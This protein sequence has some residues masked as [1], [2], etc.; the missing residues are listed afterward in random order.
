MK[1]LGS[2]VNVCKIYCP[3][4][5]YNSVH[6]STMNILSVSLT[7]IASCEEGIIKIC[8]GGDVDC[9]TSSMENY[10]VGD[11]LRVGRVEVCLG[12]RYGTICEDTWDYEDAS[13]VCR[14]LNFSPYGNVR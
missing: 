12:G 13:V 10:L 1:G 6:S 7:S 2:S 14:Q 8:P 11:Q 4:H 5:N 3:D 9:V